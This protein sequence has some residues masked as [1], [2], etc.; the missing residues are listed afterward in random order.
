MTSA[1]RARPRS[2]IS[3]ALLANTVLTALNLA[4]RSVRK[5]SEALA[6]NTVLKKLNLGGPEWHDFRLLWGR[7]QWHRRRGSD[8]NLRGSYGQHC[9]DEDKIEME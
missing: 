4:H 7:N 6:V 1:P 3:E 5:I 2:E 8:R 9:S